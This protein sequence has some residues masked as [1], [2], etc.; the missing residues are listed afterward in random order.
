MP[1]PPPGAPR[2]RERRHPISEGV[3][4]AIAD[5]VQNAT[6]TLERMRALELTVVTI[7]ERTY[8]RRLTE[9][10]MPPH[11][12]FVQGSL[13]ALCHRR[14]VAVVGTRRA[15][16]RGRTS[17]GRI[18]TSLVAAD[19]AVISGLAYGIDGAAHAAAV[20]AEGIT[21][22]VIGGGHAVS[23]P[24]AHDRL[25]RS[26]LDRG[27]AVVSEF[28]PDAVP[29]RG[30]FPRRNRII[31]GLADATVVVE[32]PA[33]SGALIT[34]S[35][36]LE[37]GRGC[38]LVPGPLDAHASAGCLSFLREFHNEARIVSGIPQLIADLGLATPAPAVTADAVVGST[39]Q[40]L[41]TTG[42]QV[43]TA[44]LQGLA[45][46]DELVAA[47]DLPVAAVLA[48]LGIL[49]G[50]GLVAGIHG[51]YRPDGALLGEWVAPEVR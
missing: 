33:R 39:L 14:A 8:P 17:A 5:A 36:A 48:S 21:V 34:A 9:I 16:T 51:R 26:I 38:F 15:T 2:G 41:G 13:G 24:P 11:L 20:R 1:P 25:A 47:T 12:L 10:A 18:A 30:T 49:E 40:D 45:T 32:A 31:S 35:W 43:A 19:A 46:V 27:G 28:A 50:R 6:A 29:T 37:Q 23:V 22:A 44:L 3:A 7:E 4:I 42:R